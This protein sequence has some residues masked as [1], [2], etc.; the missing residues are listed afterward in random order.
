MLKDDE[1]KEN[2]TF[3][4]GEL[5]EEEGLS[6]EIEPKKEEARV[7]VLV[8]WEDMRGKKKNS[9]VSFSLDISPP[10]AFRL[11]NQNTSSR[12]QFCPLIKFTQEKRRLTMLTIRV[13]KINEIML[14]HSYH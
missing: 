6:Q 1:M 4:V 7:D 11:P 12:G 3:S 9:P 14:N 5:L 13:Q 2:T 8:G 10:Y